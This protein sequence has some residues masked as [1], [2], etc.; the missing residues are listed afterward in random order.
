M[1]NDEVEEKIESP[2]EDEKNSEKDK[3]SEE[4][5]SQ[6]RIQGIMNSAVKE[7]MT[8][9]T[10]MQEKMLEPWRPI[11]RMQAN[12][13]PMMNEI[14]KSTINAISEMSQVQGLSSAVRKAF[15][16]SYDFSG[17]YEAIRE[18]STI[19]SKAIQEIKIPSI[20]EER[21]QELIEANKLWGSYGWTTNPCASVEMVF[22]CI[23]VDKKTADTIA[24][25]QCSNQTMEQIFKLIGETKG[26]KK[27]DIE[28][29]VFDYEHKQYKSCAFILFSL[30]E[31]ILIRRQGKSIL[32]GKRRK[33]GL[34]AVLEA[35][36]Q[37]DVEENTEVLF[38]CLYLENIFA[39]LEKVFES[40]KDFKQQPNVINRNFLDHGMMTKRVRKKDCIQLFLLYYNVLKLTDMID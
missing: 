9:I 35:K 4:K 3:S 38:K 24:L 11:L 26:V 16:I 12:I 13:S 23:S 14:R 25:E 22:N 1:D 29:A 32:N 40:G 17:I 39:C 34:G 10:K 37:I 8:S 2:L 28:E 18:M 20:S 27:S 33:V 7:N 21:K 6:Q 15:S 31:A 36:K 19:V 5:I 30:M